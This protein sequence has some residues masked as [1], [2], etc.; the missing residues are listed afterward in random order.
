MMS[1]AIFFGAMAAT[2]HVK[3]LSKVNLPERNT[4]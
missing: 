3:S 4:E 1:W 2:G